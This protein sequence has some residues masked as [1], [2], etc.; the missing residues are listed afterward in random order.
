MQTL[1]SLNVP[2]LASTAKLQC[3]GATLKPSNAFSS[4][5]RRQKPVLGR[6]TQRCDAF[7]ASVSSAAAAAVGPPQAY[8]YSLTYLLCAYRPNTMCIDQFNGHTD[9]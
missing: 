9:T 2:T 7:L 8:G 5:L 6:Q 4:A 1:S 3:R